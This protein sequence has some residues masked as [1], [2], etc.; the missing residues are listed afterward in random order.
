MLGLWRF[1]ERSDRHGSEI[2]GRSEL[3]GGGP[4]LVSWRL[5]RDPVLTG[6]DRHR[7]AGRG[8]AQDGAVTANRE[9]VGASVIGND[10]HEPREFGLE[11]LHLLSCCTLDV[12][13]IA[14][15][16]EQ[17]NLAELCPRGR[18][19]SGEGMTGRQLKQRPTPGV[20]ALAL[21]KLRASLLVS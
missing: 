20:E 4:R 14:L 6:I 5:G 7:R 19:L 11:G 3:D 12:R 10:D 1:C 16:R 15:L 17:R 8:F 21:L 2:A 9:P 18:G 13:S